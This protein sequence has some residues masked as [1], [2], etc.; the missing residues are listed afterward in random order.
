MLTKMIDYNIYQEV[1]N[2]SQ[3][4]EYK[5]KYFGDDGREEKQ[6]E[7]ASKVTTAMILLAYAIIIIFILEVLNL[8]EII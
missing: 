7:Q 3:K 2:M 8:L 1:K 5:P 6:K 4:E